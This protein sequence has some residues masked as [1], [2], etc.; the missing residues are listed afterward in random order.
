VAAVVAC[1][2]AGGCGSKDEFDQAAQ[3]SPETLAQEL[4]FRYRAL[5]PSARV[6]KKKRDVPN[7][8]QGDVMKS[9]DEQSQVKSQTKAATKKAPAAS[10]DD[11][12]D[13]IDAKA[14]RVAG[15]TRAQ[16]FETMA[17][18]IGKESS[19]EAADRETL[20]GKLREM[21]KGD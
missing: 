13:E 19:L 2:A 14:S 5:S 21:A 11:L 1:A 6:V 16:V 15:R 10:A 20:A 4:A 3:Y 9:R 18:A 7:R 17:E 8:K 12:L